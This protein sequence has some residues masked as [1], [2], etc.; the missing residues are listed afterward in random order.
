M[1]LR[2]VSKPGSPYFAMS[3]AEASTPELPAWPTNIGAGDHVV[4]PGECMASIADRYGFFWQTLWDLPE[5]A[6]LR[7]ARKDPNVLQPGDRVFVPPLRPRSCSRAVDQRHR[8]RR[9]GIPERFVLRLTNEVEDR[10]LANL[11][12]RFEIVGIVRDGVTDA[13]GS[14]GEWIPPGAQT[15]VLI[16]DPDGEHPEEFEIELG[17]LAPLDSLAGISQR[18][19]ALGFGHV[20]GPARGLMAFQAFAGLEVTGEADEASLAKLE[21]LFGR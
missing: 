7:R 16:L 3:D 4:A 1:Q 9:R 8:F 6:E 19:T 13:D 10:S 21:Q 2:W 17:R 14:L 15:A 18:L 20:D 5:N 11:P 12:Y